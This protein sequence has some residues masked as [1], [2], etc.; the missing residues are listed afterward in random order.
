MRRLALA[1]LLLP[2]AALAEDRDGD[3]VPDM[4]DVC[5]EE[6][7][8]PGG[9]LPGCPPPPPGRGQ[10]GAGS[11][12]AAV[13][14]APRA[15]STPANEVITVHI[16]CDDGRRVDV[17]LPPE[18]AMPAGLTPGRQGTL[19]W[20]P[21]RAILAFVADD[22]AVFRPGS[23]AAAPD[24]HAEPKGSKRKRKVPESDASVY[25][26]SQGYPEIEDRS[27]D[28]VYGGVE[29]TSF[30]GRYILFSCDEGPQVWHAF[31]CDSVVPEDMPA[32][33]TRATLK[34][35][36]ITPPNGDAPVTTWKALDVEGRTIE[37]GNLLDALMQASPPEGEAPPPVA[38]PTSEEVER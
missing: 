4:R 35:L 23:T 20:A 15:D 17:T 1:L 34:W 12:P 8:P 26:V 13:V 27:C 29:S 9:E 24:R 32:P 36:Q 3:R 28:G 33:G 11:C 2:T 16:Q 38:P 14:F 19:T 37:P 31:P 25:A 10:G 21:E 22:G 5:P 6:A 30:S 7:G 18:A